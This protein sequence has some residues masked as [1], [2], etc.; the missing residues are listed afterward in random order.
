MKVVITGGTGFIGLNLAR[1]LV[2]C[3]SLTGPSGERE[4]IDSIVLFDAVAP[5]ER[6]SGLDARIEIVTGDIAEREAVFG[7]IDRDDVSVFHLAS[8]VSA[9]GE[10]DFDLALSV[11]LDGGRNVLEACRSRSGAPRVV[12]A[13]SIAVFGGSVMP[14]TVTDATKRTPQ[15]TYGMTKAIGELMINDYTRKGFIDGRSARLP[16]IIIRPGKP[17]AAASSF[18]SGVFREPLNGEECV[19]PVATGTLMPVLGYRSCVQGFI[20]LHEA[21]GAVLGD[22]R[23]VNLPGATYSVGEMIEALRRVAAANDRKLGSITVSP[24]PVIQ[25]IVATWPRRGKADRALALGLPE[26]ESLERVIQDYIDDFL[27]A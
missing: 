20:V 17:N 7:L 8:V 18:A 10:Q 5:A 26:D 9:G 6:P 27:T 15:T 4:E 3:G 21:D 24:D 22:D 23:A 19:L 1:R 2:L 25:K 11:N 13:S 12:F 16:T 14:E